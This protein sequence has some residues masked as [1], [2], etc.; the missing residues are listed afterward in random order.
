VLQDKIEEKDSVLGMDLAHVRTLI[1]CRYDDI[2]DAHGV[3]Q[4]SQLL[5]VLALEDCR[6]LALVHVEILLHLRY[7]G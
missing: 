6:T 4:S 7:L 3:A 1:V 2:I 5:R